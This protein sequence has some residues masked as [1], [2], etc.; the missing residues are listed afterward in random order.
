MTVDLKSKKG[1]NSDTNGDE[2]VKEEK[3][4]YDL[5]PMKVKKEKKEEE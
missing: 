2:P 3:N 5:T 1:G 4:V